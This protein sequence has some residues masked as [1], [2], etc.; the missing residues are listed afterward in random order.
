MDVDDVYDKKGCRVLSQ[1]RLIS[2]ASKNHSIFCEH[3]VLI[4]HRI[5]IDDVGAVSERD[6]GKSTALTSDG[7]YRTK[8]NS[9]NSPL[10]YKDKFGW[11]QIRASCPSTD[12]V[13]EPGMTGRPKRCD[14]CD[15]YFKARQDKRI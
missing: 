9:S 12:F 7:K 6:K 4:R 2:D 15:K 3:M 5:T 11:V 10:Q 13:V 8:R 1:R 14:S